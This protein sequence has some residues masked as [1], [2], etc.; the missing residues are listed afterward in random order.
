VERIQFEG[1]Q[2][3]KDIGQKAY[4]RLAGN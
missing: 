2:F 4:A 3:R 1:R